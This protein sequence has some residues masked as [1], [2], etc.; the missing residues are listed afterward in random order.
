MII[1]SKRK[2][3]PL[4]GTLAILTGV[5]LVIHGIGRLDQEDPTRP[6]LNILIGIGI[7]IGWTTKVLNQIVEIIIND[8]VI[9]YRR[10]KGLTLVILKSDVIDSEVSTS[11]I[12]FRYKG[13]HDIQGGTIP[14][15]SF[16][17]DD[18]A[19]IRATF[20]NEQLA[21]QAGISNGG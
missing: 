17:A 14:F 5:W 15:R 8:E 10:R 16:R 11:R 9:E 4:I 2:T 6:W 20:T 13:P 18:V 1:T 21:Q 19:V 7:V 12:K 3:F